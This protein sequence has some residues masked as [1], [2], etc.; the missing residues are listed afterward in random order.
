M[1]IVDT[2]VWIDFLKGSKDVGRVLKRLLERREVLGLSIVFGELLQG[3]RNKREQETIDGFWR[4]LPK[5]DESGLLI[6]VGLLS[7]EY[8]LFTKGVGL[9]DCAILVAAI[10]EDAEIW[11]FDKKL[12]KAIEAIN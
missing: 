6:E 2:S 8:K 1:T 9:L 4:N 3:A 5:I 11:T 7:S 12:I 10:R